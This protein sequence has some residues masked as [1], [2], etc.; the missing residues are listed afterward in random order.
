[1]VDVGAKQPTR[2]VAVAAGALRMGRPAFRLLAAGKLPKGDALK[3]GEVAG[4]LAAKNAASTIPLC[5]PLPLD[6]VLVSFTLD[7]RLPGV[8]ARCE[9]ATTAKTGVEMEAL[10][11]ATGALLAVYDLVKQVD[12]AL[13]ISDV[14]LETK[15]GGKS[16]D[17]RHP[18]APRMEDV[19]GNGLHTKR[20]RL[21]R[22]SVITVSDSRSRGKAEDLSGPVLAAGLK[23]LGFTVGARLLVPDEREAIASAVAKAA[24]HSKLVALT[25]GTGLSPRDVTPE[26]VASLCDRL[27]P[28]IGEALR[29][30]GAAKLPAAALSRS[31]AGQLG[32]SLVVCLPGS[33]GGVSDALKVLAPLLPHAL[34]V[35]AGGGH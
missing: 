18:E 28:G 22:A 13:T 35:M 32:Q 17:W 26:T 6:R 7:E 31:L 16:G 9:C 8:R 5:H 14:R 10:A 33:R 4:V 1:M 24:K 25:G 12:A 29:A 19:A 3:L 2:R 34:H 27:I 23:E 15:T 20:P 21:G 11:G 30:D